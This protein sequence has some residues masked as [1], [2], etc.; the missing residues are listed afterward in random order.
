M[1]SAQIKMHK[2]H[3]QIE[4]LKG[5]LALVFLIGILI[6]LFYMFKDADERAHQQN[7]YNCAVYGYHED[8]KTPLSESE[9]LK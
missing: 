4:V 8:C 6:G 5:L 7:K 1:N 9:R 2:R 3:R